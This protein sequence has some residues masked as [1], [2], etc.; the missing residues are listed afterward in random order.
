MKKKNVQE[1]NVVSVQFYA[2]REEKEQREMSNVGF[3]KEN[4]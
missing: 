3:L 2:K 1:F 4:Q